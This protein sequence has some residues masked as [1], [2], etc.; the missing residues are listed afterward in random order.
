MPCASEL[1]GAEVDEKIRTLEESAL[2]IR[3]LAN[4]IPEHSDWLW[5]I[6]SQIASEVQR[7]R[8]SQPPFVGAST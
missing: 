3:D 6:E 5:R 2:Y 8:Q 4:C 1:S 7:L